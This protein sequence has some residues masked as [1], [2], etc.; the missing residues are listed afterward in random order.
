MNELIDVLR[1]EF[2]RSCSRDRK[3]TAILD[4]VESGMATYADAH[5]LS[6]LVGKGLS[7]SMLTYVTEDFF[8]GDNFTREEA[9][10]LLVPMLEDAFERISTP[11]AKIQKSLNQKAGLGLNA[12][13]P[14]MN[15]ERLAGLCEKIAS[16]SDYVSAKWMLGD[17]VVNYCQNVVD[18]AIEAN[19][20]FHY[21][22]GLTP[23]IIRKPD[24][25]AC[26][27]CLALAG[28]Y[29]YP[30]VPADVY[31]RHENCNCIVEYDPADGRNRRQN[32]WEK[33]WR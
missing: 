19:A 12:K 26:K 23:R 13:T 15:Q 27:W 20:E 33:T 25:G 1:K 18:E 7:N 24:A 11:T 8:A 22:S 30:N 6:L 5:E 4:K 16:Y 10:E 29:I 31:R 28:E 2:S 21:Q 3:I 9:E 32:V 17:P 14:P